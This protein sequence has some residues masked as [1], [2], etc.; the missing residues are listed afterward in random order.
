MV[1]KVNDRR[2]SGPCHDEFRGPRSDYVRQ[3]ALENNKKPSS[4]RLFDLFA[5]S[6]KKK[7]KEFS[8]RNVFSSTLRQEGTFA[9]HLNKKIKKVKEGEKKLL[10]ARTKIKLTIVP[11]DHRHV[12]SWDRLVSAMDDGKYSGTAV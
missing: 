5:E 11:S 12:I 9:G 10:S 2:T 4:V 1:L 8:L 6:E 3:V 7:E